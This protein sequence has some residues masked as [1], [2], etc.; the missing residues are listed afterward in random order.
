MTVDL[1]KQQNIS[2]EQH[3]VD[4]LVGSG[5]FSVP[6]RKGRPHWSPETGDSVHHRG[7]KVHITRPCYFCGKNTG[8]GLC[9]IE[10]IRTN[11][12]PAM[13]NR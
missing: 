2:A 6:G 10:K 1:K 9:K 11:S 12:L 5:P 8:Y 4:L 7:F 3:T 13:L